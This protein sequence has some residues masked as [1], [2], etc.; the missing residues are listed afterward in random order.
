[1]NLFA[2]VC[3]LVAFLIS[4]LIWFF[5]IDDVQD[6]AAAPVLMKMLPAV[7]DRRAN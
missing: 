6:V 7:Q 1:M 4:D 3:F 5:N 2:F